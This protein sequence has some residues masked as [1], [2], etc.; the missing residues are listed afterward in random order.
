M[1]KS[2]NHFMSLSPLVSN[3]MYPCTQC[4][5]PVWSPILLR[6]P[7]QMP[8]ALLDQTRSLTKLRLGPVSPGQSAVIL[9]SSSSLSSSSSSSLHLL[10]YDLSRTNGGR[11]LRREGAGR[12]RCISPTVLPPLPS[13]GRTDGQ[14]GR[15]GYS[16]SRFS[17]VGRRRPSGH[18]S[19][20]SM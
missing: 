19:K 6:H 7:V 11:E 9:Q 20:S 8:T 12:P 17:K 1:S 16:M 3:S 5:T 18:P 15:S 4:P 14:T 10:P 13:K 2:D